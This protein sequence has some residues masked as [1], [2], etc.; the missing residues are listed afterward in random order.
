MAFIAM[1]ARKKRQTLVTTDLNEVKFLSFH[2]QISNYEDNFPNQMIE[3]D[4]D[5]AD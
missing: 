3:Y 1:V 5:N 4:E 2:F